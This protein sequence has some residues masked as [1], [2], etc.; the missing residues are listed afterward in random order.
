MAAPISLAEYLPTLVRY[1][2]AAG[3]LVL[4]ALAVY[5]VLRRLGAREETATGYTLITPWLAGFLIWTAYPIV[6]SFYL[7]FTEYDVLQAPQ[8]VGLRNYARIFTQDV[9]FWPSI[10][11][12]VLYHVFQRAV[13]HRRV[14]GGGAPAYDEY[15]RPGCVPHDLLPAL[16]LAGSGGRAAVALAL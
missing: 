11:I 10:R 12:T 4:L 9:D 5:A 8:W 2:A 15:P 3:G 6:A 16:D 1:L 14:A 7:S 13:G